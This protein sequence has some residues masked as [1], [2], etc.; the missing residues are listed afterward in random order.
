MQQL[1]LAEPGRAS[2]GPIALGRKNHLFK[3]TSFAGSPRL[4]W[5]N[6]VLIH[7]EDHH[8][9]PEPHYVDAG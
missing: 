8:N 2:A 4:N 9:R 5:R 1:G 7:Y 3:R 6:L